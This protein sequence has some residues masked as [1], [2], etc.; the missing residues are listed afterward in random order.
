MLLVGSLAS[1]S[2][3]NKK[4]SVSCLIGGRHVPKKRTQRGGRRG[5]EARPGEACAIG[6][7]FNRSGE[8]HSACANRSTPRRP[9]VLAGDQD[10]VQVDQVAAS[11]RWRD[12]LSPFRIERV[13]D[14]ALSCS[15]RSVLAV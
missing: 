10:D 12:M 11:V 6:S 8:R 5:R 15:Q 7:R 4:R 13:V 3:Q 1:Y 14:R 2:R 9:I